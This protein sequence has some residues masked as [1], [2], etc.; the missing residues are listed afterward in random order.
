MVLEFLGRL[1]KRQAIG[2]QWGWDVT[3]KLDVLGGR[4]LAMLR[5]SADPGGGLQVNMTDVP[6]SVYLDHFAIRDISEKP[7]FADRFVSALDSLAGTLCISVLNVIEFSKVTDVKSVELAERLLERCLPRIF[8]IESDPWV[9]IRRENS[10]MRGERSLPPHGDFELAAILPTLEQSGVKP[11]GI[12]G[13]FAAA[14]EA[15]LSDSLEGLGETFLSR[16][17]EM[18]VQFEEDAGLRSQASR[19]PAAQGLQRATRFL[20]REIVRSSVSNQHMNLSANDAVD[21]LHSIVPVSYCELV[22]LDRR[23][24]SQVSQAITRLT[25][26]GHDTEMAKVYSARKKRHR[27]SDSVSRS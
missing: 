10:L 7:A 17:A 19:V 4:E 5:L 16:I 13:L 1:A 9:V 8:L 15:P 18:R 26:G 11:L 12:H 20:L 3:S 22:I 14:A 27:D 23:W 6:P 2:R 25:K 21:F 24:A